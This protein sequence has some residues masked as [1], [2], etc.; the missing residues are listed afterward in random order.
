[1]SEG[2]TLVAPTSALADGNSGA[3]QVCIPGPRDRW[4]ESTGSYT[5]AELWLYRD[6]TMGLLR[7]YRRISIEVGR[8]PSLLGRELF[9]TRVS[10]YHVTSFEEAVIFVRDVECRLQKLNEVR[11][12]TADAY[13]ISRVHARRS[14]ADV[15]MLA[16]DDRAAL[17]RGS[18]SAQRVFT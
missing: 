1:M 2:G 9:R 17:C 15:G 18:R 10:S 4:Q 12:K 13:H 8:L 6:R 3:S 11:P 7:R 16:A 5:E 14:S